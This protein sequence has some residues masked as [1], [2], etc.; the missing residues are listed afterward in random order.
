MSPAR[1]NYQIDRAREMSQAVLVELMSLATAADR[2]DMSRTRVHQ[3]VH[4]YAR[5]TL[6]AP[7][8]CRDLAALRIWIRNNRVYAG[9]LALEP[10]PSKEK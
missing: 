9:K 1:S 3:I 4:R 10:P 2:W 8:G 6:G 5:E 7:D